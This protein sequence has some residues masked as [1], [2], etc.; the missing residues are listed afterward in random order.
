V[1][2]HG[3]E[4]MPTTEEFLKFLKERCRT[5]E[6]LDSCRGKSEPT[7]KGNIKKSNKRVTLASTSQI[8]VVCKESHNIF[9]CSEFLKLPIQ[10][11]IAEAKRQQLC[12]NCLRAGHYAKNCRFSRCRKCSKLH[13]TLLHIE[14]TGSSNKESSQTSPKNAENKEDKENSVSMHCSRRKECI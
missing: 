9:N 2:Q 13:N 10:D 11:R 14:P 5:L 12:I 1:G 4:H 7:V 3:P 8:C 6:M